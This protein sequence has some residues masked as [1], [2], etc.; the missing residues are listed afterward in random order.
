MLRWF[1]LG[2]PLNRIPLALALLEDSPL[3]SEKNRIDQRNGFYEF[4]G[5]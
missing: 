1:L 4:R 5:I 3:L 2:P